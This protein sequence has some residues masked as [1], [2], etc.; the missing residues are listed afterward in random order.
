MAREDHSQSEWPKSYR[1]RNTQNELAN[2]KAV[3]TQKPTDAQR[4]SAPLP[5]QTASQSGD[6][7]GSASRTKDIMKLAIID[8]RGLSVDDLVGMLAK[9]GRKVSK[10]TV[11]NIRAEFL[12]SLRLLDREGWLRSRPRD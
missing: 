1:K 2:K 7:N 3:S 4:R 8:D 6:T 11:G 10:V 12:H 9:Q 5:S